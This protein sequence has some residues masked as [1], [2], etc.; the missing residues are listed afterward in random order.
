[1]IVGGFDLSLV[2]PFY[3]KSLSIDFF[4]LSRGFKSYLLF[5]AE[6]IVGGNL[7]MFSSSYLTQRKFPLT[8]LSILISTSLF[9]NLG[10]RYR[11]F[12]LFASLL[13]FLLIKEE[14][15]KPNL[16]INLGAFSLFLILIF[17]GFVEQI[18]TY[19][20]GFNFESIYLTKDFLRNIFN[21]QNQASF[22]L[23]QGL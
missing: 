11:I 22:L 9:L 14:K 3:N 20:T 15:L 19:G 4:S 7:L 13:L 1:M 16:A 2:N 18:R 21:H 17:M 12:F 10:F 5:A 6:F 23:H 8:L